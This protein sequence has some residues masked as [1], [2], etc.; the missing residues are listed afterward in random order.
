MITDILNR[1]KMDQN[2]ID[3][4]IPHQASSRGVKAYSKFGDL[5]KTK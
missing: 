4:L 5:T 2:D 3:L 1:N